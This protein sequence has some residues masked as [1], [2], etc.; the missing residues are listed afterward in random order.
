MTDRWPTAFW[1]QKFIYW[2]FYYL[3]IHPFYHL[4]ISNPRYFLLYCSI[5]FSFYIQIDYFNLFCISNTKI[6]PLY[7]FFLP[8]FTNTFIKKS[9]NMKSIS[10]YIFLLFILKVLNHLKVQTR[11]FMA[12]LKH[13]KNV[14]FL[15]LSAIVLAGFVQVNVTHFFKTLAAF[16]FF[17]HIS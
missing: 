11:N 4:F 17:L 2:F 13:L 14:M 16:L 3:S 10:V 15:R 9:K 12:F 6:Q 1:L 5:F 7:H 8:F